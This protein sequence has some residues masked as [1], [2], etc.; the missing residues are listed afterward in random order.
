MRSLVCVRAC[1]SV[2]ACTRIQSGSGRGESHATPKQGTV[3][4]FI[5]FVKA[6]S[7]LLPMCLQDS[8]SESVQRNS[9]QESRETFGV[10][11]MSYRS[12]L[13]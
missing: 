8:K 6:F 3:S 1:V 4:A 2:C 13:S 5:D 12:Q 10:N 11:G 7:M 9:A